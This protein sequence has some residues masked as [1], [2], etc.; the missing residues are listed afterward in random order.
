MVRGVRITPSIELDRAPGLRGNA[1]GL[2]LKTRAHCREPKR[3]LAGS[4]Q[5][6]GRNL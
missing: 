1:P 6:Q 2:G 5:Q 4:Y 3:A